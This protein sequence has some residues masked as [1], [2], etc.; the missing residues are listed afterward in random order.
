MT[1]HVTIC[2]DTTRHSRDHRS[3]T[4]TVTAAAAEAE[5]TDRLVKRG[6]TING[7][8]RYAGV[9]RK[10]SAAV[11][12]ILA[13]IDAPCSIVEFSGPDGT[14]VKITSVG[15]IAAPEHTTYRRLATRSAKGVY[16]SA[17][18]DN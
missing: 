1:T 4:V 3:Y 17:E 12:A 13:Y 7:M 10:R 11:A 6:P 16:L 18:L 8:A 15:K 14:D 5:V 9:W 2:Y